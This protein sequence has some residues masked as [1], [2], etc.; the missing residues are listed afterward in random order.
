[1]G[2][3]AVSNLAWPADALEDG[4]ALLARLGCTAVE[5]APYA[6]FARWT[7]L[8]DDARRLR[9]RLDAHGLEC[10]ALQGILFGADD[11][12]LFGSA[13]QQARFEQHLD[14]VAA[15]AGL[16]GARACVFGAPRQ[17]DPGE[18]GADEA[19][20]RALGGL[21]R[22]APAFAAVGSALAFEAVPAAYGNRF[23]TTT[24]EAVRLVGEAGAPGIGLQVDTGTLFLGTEDPAVLVGAGPLAVHM[25]VSEPELAPVGRT[26]LDHVPVAAALLESGYEGSI[27][28]EMR[29]VADWPAAIAEAV[30][31]VRSTYL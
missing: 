30:G 10:C 29:P 25:H 28:I 27:S 3:L 8:A 22:I 26:G 18:L 12:S 6:V 1:M 4:L 17:R 7:D 16:L 23:V 24:A 15:L 31:F 14:G 21:R 19:W 11:V 20:H 2:P 13:A 9:D 5:I